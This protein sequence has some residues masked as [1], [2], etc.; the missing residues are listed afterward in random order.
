M[1]E[2]EEN[3]KTKDRVKVTRKSL[4]R[5]TVEKVPLRGFIL[6]WLFFVFLFKF[7]F[8][9]FSFSDSSPTH[10]GTIQRTS[11]RSKQ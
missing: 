8:S 9:F 11:D 10:S 1:V 5:K 7:F 3:C 4:R 6:C 2:N